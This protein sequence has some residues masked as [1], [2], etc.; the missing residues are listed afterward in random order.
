MKKTIL[1]ILILAAALAAPLQAALNIGTA[2]TDITPPKRVPLQ[3]QFELR[4]SQ[5]IETP[6]TAQVV[7]LES[8]GEQVIFV[9]ADIVQVHSELQV[10]IQQKV[11]TRETAI[12]PAKIIINATH[13]HTAPT[14]SRN[15]PKLPV[16]DDI[17]DYPEAIDFTAG[18]I[19]DA[20]AA[21]WKNRKPG[22]MAFGLDFAV[23]GVN[24]RAVYAD[25]TAE[26]Y[27]NTQR[28]EF[29]GLE[30]KEDYDIGTIFFLD[31]NDKM[32]AVAVNVACPSQEVEA[33]YKINAD[34]WHPVRETLRKRFGSDLV[35]LGWI[36]AS[37]DVSPHQW[38]VHKAAIERMN[39]LRKLDTL[40]E[41]TRKI[42]RAVADTWEAV[43]G[44]AT[45]DVPLAHRVETLHLPMRKVTEKEYLAAKAE[46]DAIAAKL[47]AN[48]DKAPAEVDWMAGIWHNRVLQ[49][50][51]VQQKNP[52]TRNPATIHVLRLG[53]VAIFTNPFELFSDYGI[54]MKA[55]S[56]AV[57]TFV[58]QLA[59][60]G[61][62]W[63]GYLPTERAVKGGHYSAIIQSNTI[64]PEGGQVLVEETLKR[65]GEL[66]GK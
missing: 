30:G 25:G 3:G 44:T 35:V 18:R 20:I 28:A 60:G 32:I 59:D 9:T 4:L 34:Y 26:M 48:P 12:N 51:E 7:A 39:A 42:D 57:Q 31:A 16:A 23:V 33:H 10:A 40:Q 36:G 6:L 37:G 54:Q 49:R 24:R 13:T 62:V 58:V 64:G 21:A 1:S 2:Q 17:M 15:Y 27:G 45:A 43:K 66:F 14:Y 8:A 29:R 53:E 65:A 55:R 5:G 38:M 11:A 50:Y 52:E 47:K 41:I 22:K 61:S 46:C 19:A 63:I 56:P